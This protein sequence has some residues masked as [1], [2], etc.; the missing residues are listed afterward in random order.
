MRHL[1]IR[2]VAFSDFVEFIQLIRPLESGEQ[3]EDQLLL[4]I[5][6]GP[7]TFCRWGLGFGLR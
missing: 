1:P 6:P 3:A 7:A 4:G 2:Q 5:G